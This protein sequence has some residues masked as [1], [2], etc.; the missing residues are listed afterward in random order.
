MSYISIITVPNVN[1]QYRIIKIN[2]ESQKKIEIAIKDIEQN[3]SKNNNKRI[4]EL[5]KEHINNGEIFA[6]YTLLW[7]N[8]ID[9]NIFIKNSPKCTLTV[10][11]GTRKILV[12]SW[13]EKLNKNS[14]LDAKTYKGKNVWSCPGGKVDLSS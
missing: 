5:A 7:H 12:S 9:E 2:K 6:G 14:S 4:L 11:N 8:H 10:T 13:N 1:N 3:Y